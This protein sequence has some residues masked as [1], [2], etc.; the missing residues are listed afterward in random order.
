MNARAY[1]IDHSAHLQPLRDVHTGRFI[2]GFP[3]TFGELER[4]G[5]KLISP[6]CVQNLLENATA[7]VDSLCRGQDSES[8]GH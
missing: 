2:P 3:N 7:N 6:R 1:R 4:L 8:T 5:C